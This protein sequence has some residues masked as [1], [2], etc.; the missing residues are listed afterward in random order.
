MAPHNCKDESVPAAEARLRLALLGANGGAWDWDLLSGEAW[1]SPEMYDLWGF[2]PGESTRLDRSLGAVLEEDRP[3]VQAAVEKAIRERSEYRCEFRIRHA[4]LGLRWMLSHGSVTFD[5]SG[6]AV[7]MLGISLDVTERKLAE[8]ALQNSETKFSLAFANNPAAIALTDMESGR[9]IDVND[10]WVTLTEYSREEAALLSTRTA[11][12]WPSQEERAR[13]VAEL[14]NHGRVDRLQQQFRKKSGGLFTALVSAQVLNVEKKTLILSTLV[15]VTEQI[16]AEQERDASLRMLAASEKRYRNLFESCN[17]ALF[18]GSITA[19]GDLG[20]FVEVNALA[21]SRLGYTREEL[22][23]LTPYDIDPML[24]PEQGRRYVDQVTETEGLVFETVHRAR[25]GKDIPV[26]ISC[27]LLD[28]D[29]RMLSLSIARDITDRKKAETSMLEAMRLAQSAA[30]TKSQFLANMSHEIRTPMNGIIGMTELA[31]SADPSPQ[32]QEYL[33]TI[34]GSA[35]TLLTI[36]ND[37]LDFSKIDAGKLVLHPQPFALRAFLNRTLAILKARINDRELHFVC[38]VDEDLPDVIVGDDVRLGQIL[39]NLVGNALKFTSTGAV[40]LVVRRAGQSSVPDGHV[41]IDFSVIDTGVG[42]PEGML[43]HIL[44][45]FTQA[46]ASTTRDYGGTGLGLSISNRLIELMGGRLS[47]N[48]RERIGS[49]FS[50]ALRF[51]IASAIEEPAR[52]VTAT[53][54]KLSRPVRALLVED[55]TVNQKLMLALL[56]KHG[57]SADVAANGEDA[58][59]KYCSSALY[60][61]VLMDVQMPVM[62]GYEATR[63]IRAHQQ[64]T[65]VRTPIIALTAHALEGDDQKCLDA[66]MDDY[67]AKPIVTARLLQ[68]LR[69]WTG[70]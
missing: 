50:F 54:I 61:V 40:A 37:I 2:V 4:T 6:Q 59:A 51:R 28:W 53:D 64:T 26:E 39:L 15:D 23:T 63:R 47:V 21:C 62:D 33:E 22:V 18:L 7:R 8:Q 46:D 42:I 31:L 3:Q 58:V 17:D 48:S 68:A 19:E 9:F 55:N 35:M 30:E 44:E 60:D 34:N 24:T 13:F 11:P 10:T 43:E 69:Q 41:R 5:E 12:I 57:V 70:A 49:V 36:I 16:R 1:W 20:P 14:H 56:S 25:S 67:V 66:G 32:V 29:G 27:R 52:T 45:P 65:G 38:D